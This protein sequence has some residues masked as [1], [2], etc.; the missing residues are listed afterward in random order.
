MEKKLEVQGLR[1][2]AVMGV[3]L[4][5]IWPEYMPGGFT[6][7][8]VFFV[9][10]GY[11]ITGHIA[12]EIEEK[13]R[14]SLLKFYKRRLRRLLPAAMVVLFAVTIFLPLLPESRWQETIY[15]ILASALYV[16]NWQLAWLAVDYLGGQNAP[17]PVQHFWSLS[18]EEQFYI[19]WPLM[20]ILSSMVVGHVSSSRRVWIVTALSVI[21]VS[22]YFSLSLTHASPD[23]AYFVTHTRVWE[24]AFGGFL[25]LYSFPFFL[26][27]FRR[28]LRLLGVIL[29]FTSFSWIDKATPFPGMYALV[30]VLGCGLI[31]IA[32]RQ[33]NGSCHVY[34]A[35]SSSV[36]QYLGDASYSIYLWHWPIIVFLVPHLHGDQIGLL[37][38]VLVLI[39][40]LVIAGFSK[41][42]I[43]DPFRREGSTSKT[44]VVSS[45]SISSLVIVLFAFIFSLENSSHLDM[46]EG[47]GESKTYQ[48]VMTLLSDENVPDVENLFPPLTMVKRDIPE[49]Y[50]EGCHLRIDD[51]DLNP[52]VFGG[53]TKSSFSVFLVGDSH[54]ANWIPAMERISQEYGWYVETHTKS[55]CPVL[56]EPVTLR[57]SAYEACFRWGDGVL[58]HLLEENPDVVIFSQSAGARLYQSDSEI[59]NVIVETWSAVLEN[60]ISVVAIADTPKHQVEPAECIEKDPGCYSVYSEVIRDDPIL[61]AHDMDPRIELIDMNDVLCSSEIC[62]MVIGNVVVWRDKHHL[63]ASYSNNLYEIFYRRVKRL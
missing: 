1:A 38:G 26:V 40:S 22:F 53:N 33:E 56:A 43:E 36:S 29:I 14:F 46:N 30:P 8:D 45:V 47:S 52:C 32:G 13:G 24:L 3:L 63:T 16:E 42:Y 5:H 41:N 35:L 44:F 19:F 11:L 37:T 10:S 62:P 9:I 61:R 59:D 4:F 7:V 20:L 31:I 55:G 39:S 17:S 28:V 12:R 48:G 2:V 49:A 54:A 60:G 25:A 21:L 27:K 50:R 57:G 15:E 51:F 58:D 18:I 34:N 23:K 6:G